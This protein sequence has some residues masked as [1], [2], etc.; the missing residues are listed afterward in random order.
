MGN[1]GKG[2]SIN[3]INKLWKI[4]DKKS[5]FLCNWM[6]EETNHF[7][8]LFILTAI[9]AIKVISYRFIVLKRRRILLTASS[10][11]L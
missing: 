6:V 1:S 7:H 11:S 3:K 2:I 10:G 5:S 9:T 8:E 4:L